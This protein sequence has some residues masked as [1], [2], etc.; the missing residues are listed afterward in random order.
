MEEVL[1]LP[2]RP[3]APRLSARRR[4]A[5]LLRIDALRDLQIAM[6]LPGFCADLKEHGI[7]GGGSLPN[8]QRLAYLGRIGIEITEW[9]VRRPPRDPRS[10]SV[11]E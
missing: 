11:S 3:D 7:D 10:R 5:L 4:E 1:Q 2:T 6:A 8:V 9:S